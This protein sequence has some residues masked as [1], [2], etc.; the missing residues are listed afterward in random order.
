MINP[1]KPRGPLSFQNPGLL[2]FTIAVAQSC[3]N[4]SLQLLQL[5]EYD[6]VEM[7][8]AIATGVEK[9]V[10]EVDNINRPKVTQFG[11]RWVENQIKEIAP[12]D[13]S[14]LWGGDQ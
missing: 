4:P 5:T 8:I 12:L 3:A 14:S 9:G 1:D 2:R 7:E 6:N 10:L 11:R 13:T